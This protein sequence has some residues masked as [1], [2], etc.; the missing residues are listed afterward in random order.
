[1]AA[2]WDRA[3]DPTPSWT[4]PV[5]GAPS[6]HI[7]AVL[8]RKASHVVSIAPDRTIAEAVSLLD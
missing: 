7:A 2:H 5:W 6:M 1:M 4:A 3:M 8:K